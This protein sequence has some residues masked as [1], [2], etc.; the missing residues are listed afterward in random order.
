MTASPIRD[1]GFIAWRDADAGLEKMSG[2]IWDTALKEEAAIWDSYTKRIAS[3]SIDKAAQILQASQAETRPAIY[4]AGPNIVIAPAGSFSISWRWKQQPVASASIARHLTVDPADNWKAYI[5]TDAG[6]GSE[7]YKLS[8]VTANSSQPVWSRSPVG[9]NCAVN[10]GRVYY[11][12]AENFLRYNKLYSCSAVDGSDERLLYEEKDARCNLFLQ[13]TNDGQIFLVVDNA[14]KQRIA[15]VGVRGGIHW[16]H[17][18]PG[19]AIIPVSGPATNPN[20]IMMDTMGDYSMPTEWKLPVEGAIEWC[21]ASLRSRKQGWIVTRNHGERALY[22]CSADSTPQLKY[23]VSTGNILY[24]GGYYKNAE[25]IILI[26]LTPDKPVHYLRL[27]SNAGSFTLHKL[28]THTPLAQCKK[29][30]AKSADGTIVHGRII[31]TVQS[32]KGLLVV[33]YGAYGMPTTIGTCKSQWGPLLMNGWAIAYAF[34]RGGGDNTE[35]WVN[36]GRHLN[37]ERSI[38]DFEAIIAAAQLATG[39]SARQT[40]IYGRSAGGLLVGATLNR[41]IAKIAG[42]YTEVPYVDVLRT[43]SNPDLPLTEMEYEEFGNP[44][45]FMDFMLLS[46]ISPIDNIRANGPAIDKFVIC[47]SGLKDKEVFPYEPVKWIRALRAVESPA[48]KIGLKV[49]AMEAEEGHFY[50][51]ANGVKARAVDLEMIKLF[52]GFQTSA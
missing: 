24:D 10:A 19:A 51:M 6:G 16:I 1:L 18:V 27:S 44:H 32:P 11:L 7:S 43:S 49:L 5:I 29:I 23:K 48:T 15:A 35:D 45:I 42:V 26:I 31:S 30:T 20:F 9:P 22:W 52:L 40:V 4:T 33:G 50:S 14:G 28:I 25:Q 8:A 41:G 12:G 39:V 21:S 47:R 46:S 13:T 17:A 34:I 3:N 36:A 37:R 2:K 38:E